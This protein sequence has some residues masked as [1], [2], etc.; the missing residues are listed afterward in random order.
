MHARPRLLLSGLCL[1]LENTAHQKGID[2]HSLG[3]AGTGRVWA[4]PTHRVGMMGGPRIFRGGE[5]VQDH[6]VNWA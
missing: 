2:A 3:F 1:A 5:S 4:R 6:L